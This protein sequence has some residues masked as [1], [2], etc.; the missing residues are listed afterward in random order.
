[1]P[2]DILQQAIDYAT[3]KGAVVVAAA[4][5]NGLA[6]PF[7]PANYPGVIGVAATDKTDKLYSWSE[8]GPWVQVS[9]PG[10]NVAPGANGGGYV[11]FC[12]TSS[13][14]PLVA[15]LAALA[16]SVQP[17]A[18]PAQVA[19]AIEETTR[20][21]QADL[22]HGRI[23]AN[24]TLNAISGTVSRTLTGKGTHSYSFTTTG[25]TVSV[26]ARGAKVTLAG[27]TTTRRLSLQLAAGTYRLTVRARAAYT[28]TLVYPR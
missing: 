9:A 27:R 10:C 15:G 11:D 7:Y 13:A 20:P 26:V 2:V 19:A 4:G 8:H 12:G 5:N 18:S 25:G 24:A 1:V 28:V 6:A 17:K 21:V 14:T 16:L 3:G 23:D 22:L